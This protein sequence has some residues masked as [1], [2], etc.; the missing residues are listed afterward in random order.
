MGILDIFKRNRAHTLTGW[1]NMD[2]FEGQEATAGERVNEKTALGVPAVYACVRV[3]SESI[4]SLPLILYERTSEGKQRA[5]G[6]SLYPLL[7]DQSNPIMT[8]Y[9]LRELMVACLCLKGN[10]FFY[11]ERDMGEVV[12][13]W[14][15]SPDRMTV[16]AKGQHLVYTYQADDG[17]KKYR[18]EDVLHIRG[19][20]SDGIIGYSPL[21]LLR[22]N[23]SYALAVR[24]FSSNF[25]SRGAWPSGILTHPSSLGNNKEKFTKAFKSQFQGAKKAHSVF[26]L[27]GGMSWESVSVSPEQGQMIDSMKLSVVEIARIFRVPLNLVMD[28]ERST[29][30]NVTEQNRSFLTHTL[31][32]W[33]SRIEQAIFKSLLTERERERYFVEHLTADLLRGDTKERYETYQIARQAGIMSVNEIRALENM[34]KVEGGDQHE[35]QQPEAKKKAVRSLS[36]GIEARDRITENYR[37]IIFE[38]C[39]FVVGREHQ[40]VTRAIKDH[41]RGRKVPSIRTWLEEF[42]S[43]I[44]PDALKSRMGETLRALVAAIQDA[45]E[46]EIGT[47]VDLQDF[48]DDHL[49][50]LSRRWSLGSLKQLLHLLETEGAEAIIQRVDEWADDDHKAKKSADRVMVDTPNMVF[51]ATCFAAGYKIKSNTRGDSCPFCKTLDGKVVGR[52][53]PML[54]AGDWEATSGQLMRVRRPRIAPGYHAGCRCFLTHERA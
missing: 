37:S 33:L 6:H 24:R 52:G 2:A 3:L 14:P 46:N 39:R 19:L 44:F 15:I 17:E 23:F 12:A 25:F 1:N 40:S 8:S 42:Y 47:K 22:E 16:E 13:L 49:Q 38:A 45:S 35:I 5:R 27:E 53:E 32:P 9:E 4:A 30:A 7:H 28:Y 51:A 26:V 18:S 29:Y 54:A 36:G 43:D 11:V 20:S 48:F 21:D 10:A 34:N 41:E 31:R 50:H